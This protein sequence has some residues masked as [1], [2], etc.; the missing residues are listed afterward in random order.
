LHLCAG[1]H[2][3]AWLLLYAIAGL[4]LSA[5]MPYSKLRMYAAAELFVEFQDAADLKVYVELNPAGRG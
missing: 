3:S 4:H 5:S 1:L 2:L